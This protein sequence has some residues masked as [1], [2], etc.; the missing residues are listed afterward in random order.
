M[1]DD[2]HLLSL[3]NFEVHLSPSGRGGDE[4]LTRCA[5]FSEV[6]GLETNI[7]IRELREGGYNQGVRRLVAKTS[8]PSLTLKRGVTLD[9]GFWEWIQRCVNGEFP[10]PYVSGSILQFSPSKRGGEAAAA[11][12]TFTNG[13]VTK[14]KSTDLN[15]TS[16][17]AVAIEE[18]HIA[19]EGLTRV[20]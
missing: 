19:H 7:E 4:T 8:H 16:G 13:I 1:A 5:S 20:S 9:R 17:N 2:L 12:W 3:F 15:A 14:V 18:I 11:R 6:A 10:L